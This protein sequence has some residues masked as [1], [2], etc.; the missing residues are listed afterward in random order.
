MST[1]TSSASGSTSTVADDVW[2]RP[3]LSVTGTRWTRCGPPSNLRWLH[4]LSPLHQERDLV[5]PAEVGRGRSR[6]PR[7]SSPCGRRRPGTSAKRSRAN[8]LA[9]SPPSAP[10]IST[11]TFLPSF[12]VRG[13]QEHLQLAPRGA[14]AP[15]RR[16]GSPPGPARARRRWPRRASPG[17][18]PGRPGGRGSGGRRSTRGRQV[19]V[20]LRRLCGA[21]SWSLSTAGS[22][23]CASTASYSSSRSSRRSSTAAGY[24][25]QP[26]EARCT[27]SAGATRRPPAG[28]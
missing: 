24:G 12:G 9:S 2:M 8:R 11:M 10:R 3:E 26:P 17:P 6:A 23:S 19:L 5:E 4:A 28:G 16:R 27:T 14:P 25:R 15:P 22:A 13:D 21:G 18:P 7:P 1:S 20:A